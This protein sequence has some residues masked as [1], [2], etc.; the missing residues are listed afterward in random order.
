MPPLRVS[1]TSIRFAASTSFAACGTDLGYAPTTA[2]TVLCDVRTNIGYTLPRRGPVC[3]V[4]GADLG[5]APTRKRRRRLPAARDLYEPPLSA[6]ARAMRYPV[7][8]CHCGV[9][10]SYCVGCSAISLRPR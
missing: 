8:T 9:Q 5:Y 3:A 10:Y 2:H 6:Y 1:A 7:L 4:Y